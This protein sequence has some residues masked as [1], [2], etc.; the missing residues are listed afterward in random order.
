[1][2]SPEI[3]DRDEV[4]VANWAKHKKT[5]FFNSHYLLLDEDLV[6]GEIFVPRMGHQER[7]AGWRHGK[8]IQGR[9]R[10]IPGRHREIKRGYKGIR[11][12]KSREIHGSYT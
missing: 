1:L 8:K 3:E 7:Y 2:L 5:F 6:M 9:F 12:V 11:D 4:K 10:E